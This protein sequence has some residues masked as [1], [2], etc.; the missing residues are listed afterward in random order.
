MSV[1]R[2]TRPPFAEVLNLAGGKEISM[3]GTAL[4]VG[5]RQRGFSSAKS[6]SAT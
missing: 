1:P 4:D 2:R 3:P 6:I 5:K